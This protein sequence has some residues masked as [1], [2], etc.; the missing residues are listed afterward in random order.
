[1]AGVL[2]FGGIATVQVLNRQQPPA[3]VTEPT[4]LVGIVMAIG[5]TLGRFIIGP[6]IGKTGVHQVA[7]LA[8]S[9]RSTGGKEL[10]GRLLSVAQQKMIVEDALLEGGAFC[11]LMMFM[12]SGSMVSVAIVV[13]LMVLMVMNFPTKFKLARWLEDQQRLLS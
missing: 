12:I 7:E 8:R 11:N 9:G 1:M 13:G 4:V 3:P 2:M 6:M 5:V 10:F